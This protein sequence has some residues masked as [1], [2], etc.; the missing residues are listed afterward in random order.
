MKHAEKPIA[1]ILF[2]EGRT[3]VNNLNLS[4]RRSAG[5]YQWGMQ[6][7]RRPRSAAAPNTVLA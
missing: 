4:G 5:L 1:R 6:V 3:I 2:L 7:F